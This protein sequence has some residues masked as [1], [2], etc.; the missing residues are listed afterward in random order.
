MTAVN[1]TFDNLLDA[2]NSAPQLDLHLSQIHQE[3]IELNTEWKQ[4][5]TDEIIDGCVTSINGIFPSLQYT[6]NK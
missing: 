5:S 1:I 6:N 2:V 4:K 3:W